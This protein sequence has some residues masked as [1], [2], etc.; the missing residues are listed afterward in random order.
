MLVFQDLCALYLLVRLALLVDLIVLI[1][2]LLRPVGHFDHHPFQSLQ[3]HS[4]DAEHGLPVVPL[5]ASLA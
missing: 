2:H 4:A 5:L 3:F 1:F